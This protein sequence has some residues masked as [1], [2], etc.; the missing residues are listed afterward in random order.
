MTEYIDETFTDT[1]FGSE[2]AA[3]Q[4]RNKRARELRK[5]GFSVKCKT[6]DFTDLARCRSFTLE[7]RKGN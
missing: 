2:K 5:E 3:M 7:A 4:A 6:W 1:K